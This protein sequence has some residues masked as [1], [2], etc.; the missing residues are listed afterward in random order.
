MEIHELI[1]LIENR[2][3]EQYLGELAKSQDFINS[4]KSVRIPQS[5]SDIHEIKKA[6]SA[7]PNS[8]LSGQDDNAS[9]QEQLKALKHTLEE[10]KQNNDLIQYI[11]DKLTALMIDYN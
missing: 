2:E 4:Y 3:L 5:R 10:T 11:Q 9:K 6:Q 8:I 7:N 1:R